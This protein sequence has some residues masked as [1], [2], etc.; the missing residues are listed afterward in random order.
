MKVYSASQR[1]VAAHPLYC[2]ELV[3]GQILECNG[4]GRVI[5]IS[6]TVLWKK[7]GNVHSDQ[8]SQWLTTTRRLS[9][10]DTA[11]GR[12][13]SSSWCTSL[14]GRARTSSSRGGSGSKPAAADG[15][16]PA[17]PTWN[18]QQEFQQNPSMPKYLVLDLY[19][20]IGCPKRPILS[21]SKSPGDPID[22]LLR[23]HD[24][25]SSIYFQRH[26]WV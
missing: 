1:T 8:S 4:R 21:D 12:T 2:V 9:G 11:W 17:L 25:T 10:L 15:S 3:G 19:L 26:T 16:P 6:T 5:I 23:T 22:H 24:N 14:T 18:H 13:T 20:H 7:I